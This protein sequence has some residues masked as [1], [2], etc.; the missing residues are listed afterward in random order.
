MYRDAAELASDGAA[1]AV[2]VASPA[3]THLECAR[4]ASA[5]GLPALVEKPPAAGAAEAEHARRCSIRQP[6][7]GFNRRFEPGM[8]R[9]AQRGSVPP[10]SSSSHAQRSTTEAALG[11]VRRSPTMPLTS[12]SLPTSSISRGGLPEAEVV[13]ARAI[14]VD[15]CSAS[16]D[17]ELSRGRARVSVSTDRDPQDID[18]CPRGRS[19]PSDAESAGACSAGE[20]G[21]LRRPLG[22]GALVRSLALQLEEFSRSPEGRPAV[23]WRALRTAL[24]V[25]RVLDAVR[26]RGAPAETGSEV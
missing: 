13:R 11:S 15:P 6:V 22:A 9:L 5:A 17:L 16:V 25:M 20:P 26:R 23:G 7:F 3:W 2:I 1:D 4:S 19:A 21:A 18:R 12:R 14:D 24:A 8:G 10:T